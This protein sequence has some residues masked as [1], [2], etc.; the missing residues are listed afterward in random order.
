[1]KEASG[2]RQGRAGFTLLEVVVVL[3]VTAVVAVVW[4]AIV[5]PF[6]NKDRRRTARLG[7]VNNLK[8]VGLGARVWSNEGGDRFP[9][10][11]GT[12]DG[13]TAEWMATAPVSVHFAVLS[14]EIQSTKVLVC[15]N[16]TQ[17][18]PAPDFQSL[19][20]SNLTYF[21]SF[22][23]NE[24]HPQTILSGDA[25]FSTNTTRVTGYAV[26]GTNTP[27]SWVSSPHGEAGNVGLADGSVRQNTQA[28]LRTAFT[29]AAAALK[30][31]SL[32]FSFPR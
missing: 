16:Q 17:R 18:K 5:L 32:L 11:L 26:F 28:G 2:T 20:D 24:A 31:N 14:N 1:M 7:C 25:G 6:Q 4:V 9:W 8:Q 19:T 23:A 27:V 30:T 3:A 22:S 21:L 12:N 10:Q 29:N 13:G 15:P